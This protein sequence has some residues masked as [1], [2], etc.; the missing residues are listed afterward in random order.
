MSDRFFLD[1]NIFVYATTDDDAEKTR[2]ADS[3]IRKALDSRKGVVS[4]Q[5]VQ[6]F[7]NVALGRLERIMDLADRDRYLQAVMGPLLRVHSS[8]VLYSEA[9]TMQSR[10]QLSWYDSLI[11]CA[12]LQAKCTILYSEDLRHNQQFGKLRV[13]NPFL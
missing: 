12:A 1:T 2:L 7:F 8:A 6:E 10:H 4:Y 11:V 13:V 5:V 9:L 3:L